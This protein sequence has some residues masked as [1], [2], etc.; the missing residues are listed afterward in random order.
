M[1]EITEQIIYLLNKLKGML[2][3]QIFKDNRVGF[4]NLVL[5]RNPSKKINSPTIPEDYIC[6]ISLDLMKDPVIV[7]A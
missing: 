5:S 2:Q 6:P 4:E 3:M 1:G 7:A